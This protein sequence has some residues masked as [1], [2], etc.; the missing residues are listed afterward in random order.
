MTNE[1]V[2]DIIGIREYVI[3]EFK[4]LKAGSNPATAMMKQIEVA[5]VYTKVIEN[6]DY[7]LNEYVSF[8]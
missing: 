7:V 2:K 6:L 3:A 8:K 1:E 4:K 5:S